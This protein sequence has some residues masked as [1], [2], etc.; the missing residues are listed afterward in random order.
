MSEASQIGIVYCQSS[1]RALRT[2]IPDDD[3]YLDTVKLKPGE[4]IVKITRKGLNGRFHLENTLPVVLA[5]TGVEILEPVRCVVLD[6]TGVVVHSGMYEPDLYVIDQDAM[7]ELAVAS[8][9]DKNA[10]DAEAV[11]T[12]LAGKGAGMTIDAPA[13]I[14]PIGPYTLVEHKAA[15]VGDVLV[16]GSLTK[17]SVTAATLDVIAQQDIAIAQIPTP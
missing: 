9:Q 8:L 14:T 13:L 7:H 16:K 3:A 2:I 10:G 12:L 17:T 11:T 15:D 1:M 4:A 6:S 5:D